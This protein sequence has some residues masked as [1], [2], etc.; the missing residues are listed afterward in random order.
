MGLSKQAKILTAHQ[1]RAMMTFLDATRMAER[2]KLIFML[3]T[4]AGLRA[5][6]IAFITWDMVTD[7]DGEHRHQSSRSGAAG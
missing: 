4:R 1:Q 7:S 2:N 3:S 5:K 6:E